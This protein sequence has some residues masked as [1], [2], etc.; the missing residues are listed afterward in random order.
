MIKVAFKW[1]QNEINYSPSVLICT[2]IIGYVQIG[3]HGACLPGALCSRQAHG[4][5][6]GEAPK[7]IAANKSK[8]SPKKRIALAIAPL[9]DNNLND[10][11]F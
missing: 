9:V 1:D 5:S 8:I 6:H 11:F 10:I 7:P 3:L 2:A 4:M